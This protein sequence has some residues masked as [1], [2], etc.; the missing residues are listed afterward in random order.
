MN[1]SY[2]TASETDFM[3]MLPVQPYRFHGAMSTFGI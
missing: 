2:F 1:L 3:D